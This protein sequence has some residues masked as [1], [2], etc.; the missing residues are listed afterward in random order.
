[1]GLKCA[2]D[3]AQQI[4]EEV[5]CDVDNTGIYLDDIGAFSFT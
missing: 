3:F 5:L 2:P 4:M 1:M